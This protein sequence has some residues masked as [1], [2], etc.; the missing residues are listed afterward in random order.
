MEI[1]GSPIAIEVTKAAIARIEEVNPILNAVA[2]NF[3]EVL[4]DVAGAIMKLNSGTNRVNIAEKMSPASIAW[5]FSMAVLRSDRANCHHHLLRSAW[6]L[7]H[8]CPL[9]QVD[10][11]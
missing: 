2:E 4:N 5:A 3:A 10:P 8:P 7:D 11:P 6:R 1:V 9:I